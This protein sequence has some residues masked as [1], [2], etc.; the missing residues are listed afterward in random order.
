MRRP[1]Q[2]FLVIVAEHAEAVFADREEARDFAD[3]HG[4]W[5]HI[6]VLPY[7]PA[8]AWRYGITTATSAAST[9]LI[10]VDVRVAQERHVGAN[11]RCA[12]ADIDVL[13]RLHGD[14]RYHCGR[15]GDRIH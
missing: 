9:G 1:G 8:G 15:C 14:H 13:D 4:E 3:E 6:H 7:W 2:A 11:R 12:G 5:A 10:S